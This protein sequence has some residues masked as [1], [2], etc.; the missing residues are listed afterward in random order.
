MMKKNT[1]IKIAVSL[2]LGVSAIAM[3]AQANDINK[4][5]IKRTN[6]NGTA[7]NVTVYTTNPYDENV[8]VTQKGDNKYVILI[9][10]ISGA[11]A[12]NVDFS[13]LKDVVSDVNVKSVNDGAGGYTKVTLTTTKP[14]SIS[15]STRKS[16]PL[17][18]EQK[19]YKNL[20]AQSRGYSVQ[21]PKAD[22]VR[23]KA[24]VETVNAAAPV[25]NTSTP[26]ISKTPISDVQ[27]KTQE[28]AK[29]ANNDVQQKPKSV[30]DKIKNMVEPSETAK[31]QKKDSNID[32]AKVVN[33]P[34]LD[35][36]YKKE[37]GR[38]KDTFLQDLKNDIIAENKQEA[39]KAETSTTPVADTSTNVNTEIHNTDNIENIQNQTN[40]EGFNKTMITTILLLL[41][42]L[43]G[44][45]A[46]F[47]MVKKSLEH[48][49][50]L[51]RSFKENLKEKPHPRVSDYKDIVEDTSLNWQEKYQK[52]MSTME[53][54]NPE[55]GVIRQIGNGEYEY[56]NSDAGNKGI[57]ADIN[58]T[59]NINTEIAQTPK[60]TA[61]NKP[62][63]NSAPTIK[64]IQ[65][66]KNQ[67]LI[68]SMS[69]SSS[70]KSDN[71]AKMDFAKIVSNLERTLKNSPSHE[72]PVQVAD[73][74]IIKKQFENGFNTAS[75]NNIPVINEE[76][77]IPKTIKSSTKLKSFD[78][79]AALDRT[80]RKDVLPKR[81]SDIIR[82]RNIE[83]KHV[84]L[85][86]SSLYSS[87]RKFP[88][89]NMNSSDLIS[90]SAI[91]KNVAI[92]KVSTSHIKG[93]SNYS[94]A[95][96]EEFFDI[97]SSDNATAPASLSQKVADTL[98]NIGKP[99]VQ[100]ANT[101]RESHLPNGSIVLSGYKISDNGGFYIISDEEGKCSLV[102]IVNNTTTVLKEFGTTVKYRL[103]V[104]QDS[105]NVY[106][107]RVGAERFLVEVNGEKMGVL[108]AL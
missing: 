37:S 1:C 106:I 5:D 84:D 4:L 43:L 62:A 79:K 27:T 75:S 46:L 83:S 9:P 18:E 101:N 17:T 102:G 53:V 77:I 56:V 52:F 61:Y 105:Q 82:S 48:S 87:A 68:K 58:S 24:T 74:D 6:S 39:Q 44:I 92:P 67:D 54:I 10:N 34:N 23:P 49:V 66:G 30:M 50:A 19:A 72:R 100:T 28:P 51:R 93:N 41:A 35:T 107:V 86:K 63:I 3:T 89:A 47:R 33:L 25:Q 2:L 16:A 55:D 21:T 91:G 26:I 95:T 59:A 88:N 96:M 108:I 12:S 70:K 22:T 45:T 13:S 73:E 98:D 38:V 40:G 8:A 31:S 71:Q 99:K 94:M 32:N 90:A 80:R 11:N 15:T 104:R 103:Q 57:A 42:S 78:Q 97:K 60:L 69:M 29:I 64:P 36:S 65:K 7:L 81:S 85:E 76:E 14:V 20:I